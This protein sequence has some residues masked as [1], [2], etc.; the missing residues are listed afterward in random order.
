MYPQ[1]L[2]KWNRARFVSQFGPDKEEDER[3]MFRFAYQ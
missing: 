3:D 2:E 1:K